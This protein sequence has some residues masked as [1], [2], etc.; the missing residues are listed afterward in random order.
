MLKFFKKK[1][2]WEGNQQIVHDTEALEFQA[3]LGVVLLER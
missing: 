3:R 2:R 1:S